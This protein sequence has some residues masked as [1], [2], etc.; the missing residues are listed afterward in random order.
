M[1]RAFD[2]LC[3]IFRGFGRFARQIAHL[4]RHDGESFSCRTGPGISAQI[5][6]TAE[7]AQRAR[8]IANQVGDYMDDPGHGPVQLPG[9]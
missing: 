7:H 8:S 6:Q 2:Q 5:S 9:D 3:R 4:V 1:D